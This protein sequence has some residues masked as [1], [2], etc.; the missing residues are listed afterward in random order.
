MQLKSVYAYEFTKIYGAL[1][2]LDSA[3]FTNPIKHRDIIKKAEQ[4]KNNVSRMRLT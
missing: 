4:Q 1:G 3:H 2:Y